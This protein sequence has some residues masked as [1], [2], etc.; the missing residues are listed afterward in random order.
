MKRTN[1]SGAG[2]SPTSARTVSCPSSG[3]LGT[4]WDNTFVHGIKR[5]GAQPGVPL[6]YSRYLRL[7]RQGSQKGGFAYVFPELS[8][9]NFRLAYTDQ[10]L[11][12]LS[13]TTA[14]TLTTEHQ[15]YRVSVDLT[16]E[17]SLADALELAKLAYNAT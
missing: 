3:T 16:D 9:I 6:D 17:S 1:N 7:R 13:I 4:E 10:Q 8:R 2:L 14:R 15:E 11:A 5:K 12:N